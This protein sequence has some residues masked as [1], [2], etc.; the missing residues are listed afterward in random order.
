[1]NFV[2]LTPHR[3]T[4]NFGAGSILC[5]QCQELELGEDSACPRCGSSYLEIPPSGSVVRVEQVIGSFDPVTLTADSTW[6]PIIGLPEP[7]GDTIYVVSALVA[8]AAKREDVVSP[9]S[10]H[11]LTE[12]NKSGQIVSVP[13]FIR[14]FS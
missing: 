1:M 13:G 3:I 7:E 10:N 14:C 4:V 5:P 2:N 8:T 12:R 6:G 9:A 11:P